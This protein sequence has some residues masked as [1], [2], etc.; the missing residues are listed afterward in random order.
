MENLLVLT[1]A[2]KPLSDQNYLKKSCKEFNVS[3]EVLI[4]SPWVQNVVKLKMLYEFVGKSDPEL[5]ILVVDAYDV[6]VYENEEKILAKFK[7]HEADLLFSGE[8]NFMYKEPAKWFSFLKKYPKQ[9]TIY[10]YLNSGTYIGKVKH[11][12]AMLEDMQARFD[13]DLLDEERLL[14]LKSDQYLLSRYYVEQSLTPGKLTLKID[15]THDLLGVTGGR[16]CVLNFPEFSKWQPFGFFIIERNTLKLFSLHKHQ[17]VPKDYSPH[18]GRFFNR[19]TQTYPAI[20]HFPG[21]WD[22]FDRVYE[23]LLKSKKPSKG[24]NWVLAALISAIAFF[25]SLPA[26]ILFSIST[27]SIQKNEGK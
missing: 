25:L 26:S 21:T 15:A 5:V 6:V 10:Q 11:V 1:F 8:S 18:K 9:P 2:D 12:K 3:L 17:K 13:I 22:R 16:F 4:C 24:G 19:K 14:P 20:M 23:D 7:K 27:F